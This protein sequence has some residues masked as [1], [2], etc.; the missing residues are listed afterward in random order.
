MY[1]SRLFT[2]TAMAALT[3]AIVPCATPA[4]ASEGYLRSPS[5]SGGTVAFADENAVWTAPLA[6]G[7]AK[8]L[9][10]NGHIAPHPL[11]SPDGSQVAFLADVDGPTEIYVMPVSGG[12]PHRLTYE[13]LSG[14]TAPLPVAW[15]SKAGIIFATTQHS[16]PGFSRVLAHVDPAT[17]DRALYPLADANDAAVSADGKWL[18]FIRF[19]TAISGDHLRAYRGG[20][21]AQLWRYNLATGGEAQ[22]IGPQDVNL[23]RPMLWRDRLIVVSDRAGRDALWSYALDGSDGKQLTKQNDFGIMGASISGDVI[24]YRLGADL[25][26]F[27]LKTSTGNRIPI[28]VASDDAARRVHWLD[29][30][31]LYLNDITLSGN[32]QAAALTFRGHV[33]LASAGH[34]RLIQIADAP[35]LRL[36]HA[37]LAPDGNAVYAFSDASGESEIWRF[38]TDGSGKGK[39]LTHGAHSEPTGLY[40]SPDGKHI[41]HTDLLGHLSVL[42][43]ATGE[44]RLLDDATKDG[45]NVFDS[46]TWSPDSATL[47]FA[48]NRGSNV[49]RQIGMVSLDSGAV[50]WLTNGK[51]DSWSPSFSP[52]GHWLWFLSDRHFNVANSSPW[53]DRN[54]GPVFPK[55]TKIFG[56]ALQPDATFP[57]REVTEF[58]PLKDDDKSEKNKET[59]PAAVVPTGLAKRLYEAP[60]AAGDYSVLRASQDYLFALDGTEE[61]GDLKSIHVDRLEHKVETFSPN[62][63]TFDLTPD[64]KHLLVQQKSD[65][66]QAPKLYLTDAAAKKPDDLK[67]K[68]INLTSLRLKIDPVAEWHEMF[69][70]AWRLH[71]DHFFDRNLRGVD[72]NAVRTR[73]APLVNRLTDRSDLSDL[74]GQMVGE[75]NA[76]HSQLRPARNDEKPPS[77]LIAGLGATVEREPT[78]FRIVHIDAGEPERPDSL[79]PLLKPGVNARNGDLIVAINGQSVADAPSLLDALADQAGHQVLLTL[80]R[81]G[82]EIRTIVTPLDARANAASGYEDWE[83]SRAAMVDAASQGRIGYLHLRAMGPHDIDAFAREFY[84]NLDKEGL[85]IDVRRNMGGNIDSWVLTALLRRPWMFWGRYGNTPA[86]NMQQS[87]RGHIVVL[88]DEFTYSDGET[89]SLG[90]K[91][92]NIG[93]LIGMRTAGAGVWLSDG[94]TLLDK[95]NARTAE[96]PYFD[97]DGHWQVENH[98]VDPDITVENMPHATFEGEDQQLV[99][100]IDT[101]NTTIANN[102]VKTLQPDTIP[103]LDPVEK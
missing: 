25:Y 93:P 83:R 17:G 29:K 49:R 94:D 97:L 20:A 42:D 6:G 26:R 66:D 41:A 96:D 59:K 1:L 73:L 2:S 15:D 52:D 81:D 40:I 5:I 55:R 80:K 47:I 27:D 50:T 51:Y 75:L 70:D 56:L 48:R 95:G 79:P 102:P 100:A 78:G 3:L 98:G 64:G 8:R 14:R 37:A 65:P 76:L 54:L 99:K 7:A 36:R 22:R 57:F 89:F 33:V 23:R 44:N 69:A 91:A 43:V 21:V 103:A 90:V 87:F 86:V 85:I 46:V 16:S 4:S 60:I 30:P 28:T 45:T 92:L 72:W 77:D 67:T 39:Q 12:A 31:F 32:G 24:T 74:L 11:L 88:C 18:Y 53:G 68:T 38:P 35:D 58:D 62:V 63:V 61:A 34:R 13:G 71:R 101:L 19:G 84:A 9:T 10:G 82:E